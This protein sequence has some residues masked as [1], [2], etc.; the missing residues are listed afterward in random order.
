MDSKW[1]S[2]LI[3]SGGENIS[4]NHVAISVGIFARATV[5]FEI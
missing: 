5:G 3:L 2:E 4:G 1:L